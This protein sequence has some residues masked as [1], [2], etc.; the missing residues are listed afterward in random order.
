MDA[1]VEK[2]GLSLRLLPSSGRRA[3]SP[4]RVPFSD[5]IWRLDRTL[6]LSEW[7]RAASDPFQPAVAWGKVSSGPFA[8]EIPEETSV[9]AICSAS[10]SK[11]TK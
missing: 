6:S 3:T 1:P 10:H 5:A 4:L 11:Q 2:Q 9:E 8:E 7:N